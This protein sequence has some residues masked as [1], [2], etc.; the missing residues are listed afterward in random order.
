[1]T[2]STSRSPKPGL[3]EAWKDSVSF[4]TEETLYVFQIVAAEGRHL[5]E[6]CVL[7]R[8]DSTDGAEVIRI[9]VRRHIE[10]VSC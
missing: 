6:G 7:M 2:V 10:D 1:M 5:V 4:W 3:L 8:K 9:E